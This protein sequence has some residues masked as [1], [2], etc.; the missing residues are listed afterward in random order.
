MLSFARISRLALTFLSCFML[1]LMA[2]A[3]ATNAIVYNSYKFDGAFNELASIGVQR[4]Q[5]ELH[6]LMRERVAMSDDEAIVALRALAEHGLEHI[7]VLGQTNEN[8]VRLSALAFPKTKFTLIDG[9]V[10]GL[11]NVRSIMFADE[12]AGFLVGFAAGLKT[13]SNKVA[14]IGGMDLLAVRRLMCG[15]AVGAMHANPSVEILSS[16]LGDNLDAFRNAEKA[17]SVADLMLDAGADVLFA[18]A[19]RAAEGVAEAV[20]EKAGFVIMVDMNRNDYVPGKVLTSAIKRIDEAVYRTLQD[21]ASGRWEPGVT[22]LALAHN[23][24][25]WAVDENNQFVVADI[26]PAVNRLRTQIADGSLIVQPN[27]ALEYCSGA[28]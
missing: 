9:H 13:K 3:D 22:R 25:D 4:A 2:K 20:R 17:R 1:P 8:A 23:G 18:P 12:E 24:V 16:F 26:E 27:S 14:S 6:V 10:E 21:V 7:I 19:G 11:A 28:F 5:E 15:F